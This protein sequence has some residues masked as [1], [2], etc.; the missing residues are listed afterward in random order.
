[1][2]QVIQLDITVRTTFEIPDG[3]YVSP[4]LIAKRLTQIDMYRVV[5]TEVRSQVT[6]TR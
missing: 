3:D 5:R 1:M 4:E 2:A 6:V